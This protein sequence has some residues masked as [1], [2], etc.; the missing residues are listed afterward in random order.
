MS[1]SVVVAVIASVL[2]SGC[3]EQTFQVR[4]NISYERFERDSVQC[5]TTALQ[6]VPNNSVTTWMPYVGFYTEDTNAV[7]RLN[8]YNICMRDLNYQELTVPPCTGEAAS[9]ARLL[10]SDPGYRRTEM[11]IQANTCF[12]TNMS[13]QVYFYSE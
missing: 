6:N 2:V 9:V 1:K 3:V 5:R 11:R 7:L 8:N 4:Q 10:F 12:V 13:Q